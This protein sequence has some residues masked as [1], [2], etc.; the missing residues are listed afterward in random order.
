MNIDLAQVSIRGN[1]EDAL[2]EDLAKSG[3]ACRVL[4]FVGGQERLDAVVFLL[5]LLSFFRDDLKRLEPVVDALGYCQLPIV[6]T[7]LFGEISRVRSC[8][9]T[10]TYL[11]LVIKR[12]SGFPQELVAGRFESMA[13]DTSFS[14][15]IRSKFREIAESFSPEPRDDW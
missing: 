15:K 9:Q 7:A 14:P 2:A 4:G 6:A 1:I 10:R 11:T 13:D 12:L 8:N 3:Q 5:G